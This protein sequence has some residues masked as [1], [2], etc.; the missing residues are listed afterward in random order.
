VFPSIPADASM[1]Y[2]L[3]APT[4]IDGAGLSRAQVAITVAAAN[5]VNKVRLFSLY[6]RPVLK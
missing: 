5:P 2:A 3:E 6:L 4:V 1:H